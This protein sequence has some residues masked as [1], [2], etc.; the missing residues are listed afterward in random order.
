MQVPNVLSDGYNERKHID[1][2]LV[3]DPAIFPES[4]GRQHRRSLRRQRTEKGRAADAGPGRPRPPALWEAAAGA[5][6]RGLRLARPHGHPVEVGAEEEEI[7][8]EWNSNLVSPDN[9]L[10]GDQSIFRSRICF[11]VPAV[12]IIRARWDWRGNGESAPAQEED[13]GGRPSGRVGY[14]QGHEEAG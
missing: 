8:L 10:S 12:S 2:P 3:A 11:F 4:K 14:S 9:L 13:H 5:A 6:G 7:R 1:T